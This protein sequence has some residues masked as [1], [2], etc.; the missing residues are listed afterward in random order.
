M[1]K[2]N[3]TEKLKNRFSASDPAS[4]WRGLADII[5][6]RKPPLPVEANKA[7]ITP[8]GNPCP[9]RHSG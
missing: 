9:L 2:R 3:Y 6:Y 4:V 1:A 8:L 7:S 5:N